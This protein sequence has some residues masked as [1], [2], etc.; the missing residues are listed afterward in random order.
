[1]KHAWCL[2]LAAGGLLAGP[3][4]L[5]GMIVGF[6]GPYAPAAWDISQTGNLLG[7]EGGSATFTATTLTIVGGDAPSPD[8]GSDAPACTGGTYGVLGPC[9]IDVVTT[10][11]SP[12]RF[13]FSYNTGDA[14][15]P[16][17]DI[18]GVLVD[19]MHIQLSDP[20][21]PVTQTGTRSYVATTSFGWFVNCS[22]C[23]GGA[24]TTA[25][26][27]FATVPEPGGLPLA[28]AGFGA[29]WLV[30]RRMRA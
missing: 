30:R 5:A 19:G 8:P 24:A 22:D 23:I 13:D 15:G 1:M 12:F 7:G 3:P 9:E 16:P 29:A 14:D 21:G 18:F 17:G 26:S 25:V 10:V 6:N 27:G 2:A 28:L 11:A 20:G 4:A